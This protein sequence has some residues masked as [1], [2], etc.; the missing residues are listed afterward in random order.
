MENKELSSLAEGMKQSI[1]EEQQKEPGQKNSERHI[2]NHPNT[3]H[4]M[5]PLS[6]TPGAH[7]G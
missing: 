7:Y 2:R 4:G 6:Y 3:I 5:W 1:S